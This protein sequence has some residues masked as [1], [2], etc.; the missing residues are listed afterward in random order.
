MKLHT[1]LFCLLFPLLSIC[2]SSADLIIKNGRIIDG[3]GNNWFY[4]D[5]AIK[6]GKIM[7]I[8]KLQDWSATKTIDAKGM[9]VVPGFID[10]HAHIET[11]IFERPTADNFIYDG[12]TTVV[13]GNCGNSADD[14]GVFFNRIDSMKTSINIASLAG[15]N[16]IKR[17]GMGLNNRLPTTEEQAK[18]ESLMNQAMKDGAVG[19]STGL[20]YLPGMYSKTAEIVSLAK[21][22]SQ[23]N[24]VYATHMRN[25]ALKVTEAI[26][27]AL[28][29]GRQAN[30]PV[31]ISHFKV[32]G[33]AN[34]GKSNITLGKVEKA[35]KEGIDV[36]IDQYPYTA[37]STN[38][39]V[40]VPDWALDGGLD[41]LR[42][43][44]E[45][46]VSKKKII[47]GM[48][49][50]AENSKNKSFAYAV[51]AMYAPDTTLNGKNISEINQLKG[52]KKKL[53]YE[54]ETILDMLKVGNAQ[55]VYH[56]MNEKDLQYFIKYPYN[57]PAADAGVSNGKGMPH[58]RGY[59]T[60]ARVLGRYVREL[61]LIELED[62]VRRMTS[63]PAQKFGLQHKGILREGFDAD[64]VIFD[65]ATVS[66]KAEFTN[67]HQFSTGIPYVIV[68]GEVVIEHSTHTGV[69]SGKSLRKP[70]ML[71]SLQ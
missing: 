2:Q 28:T 6:D 3:T 19:L 33:K 39:A 7:Q 48:Q 47:E 55:M 49:K 25:E 24:G 14:L 37:S 59:G 46:P 15:H 35:R 27:E 67:P 4:G 32:S 8:G 68:N 43:R 36:T 5:M 62:A 60:N 21:I 69:K 50:S 40:L 42:K 61:K 51:V 1:S 64:I 34:W 57:M 30:I 29:I 13:T 54:S 44:M 65:P 17:L 71:T 52:R 23:Y 63:L 45:D 70:G 11:G 26:D 31:E 53:K 20:I 16:T 38:L 9:A 56:S 18:M 22:A 10:V 58:P 12:V 41:S 66:D